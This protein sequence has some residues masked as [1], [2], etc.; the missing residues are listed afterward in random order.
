MFGF[1]L[2]FFLSST[3]RGG[4]ECLQNVFTDLFQSIVNVRPHIFLLAIFNAKAIA[5]FYR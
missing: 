4:R 5:V 1:G 2:R 3:F